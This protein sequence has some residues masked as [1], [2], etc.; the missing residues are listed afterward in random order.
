M[1][2]IFY[3]FPL[4]LSL[5]CPLCVR[6]AYL[7]IISSVSSLLGWASSSSFLNMPCGEFVSFILQFSAFMCHWHMKK[8]DIHG[9]KSGMTCKSF[10]VFLADNSCINWICDH[11]LSW[12]ASCCLNGFYNYQVRRLLMMLLSSTFGNYLG[13]SLFLSCANCQT[14]AA[15][16]EVFFFPLYFSVFELVPNC[17]CK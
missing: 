5:L 14:I 8:Y 17:S 15:N 12:N 9:R 10:L 1:V 11:L 16:S 3:I 6:Y 2:Y 13:D 4:R 7:C